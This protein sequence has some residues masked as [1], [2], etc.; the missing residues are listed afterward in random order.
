[1]HSL[2]VVL[3]DYEILFQSVFQLLLYR[4]QLSL[5]RQRHWSL[6]GRESV[7]LQFFSDSLGFN[8]SCLILVIR[9]LLLLQVQLVASLL[10]LFVCLLRKAAIVDLGDVFDIVVEFD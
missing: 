6:F 10:L 1:M 9:L 8:W 5:S 7:G 4:L 3:L 2:L